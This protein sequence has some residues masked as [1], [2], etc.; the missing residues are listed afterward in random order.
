V[1]DLPLLW[2]SAFELFRFSDGFHLHV[3]I[4]QEVVNRNR[5]TYMSLVLLL[6]LEQEA[7]RE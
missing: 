1:V 5:G 4:L 3:V 2:I 7:L 6:A